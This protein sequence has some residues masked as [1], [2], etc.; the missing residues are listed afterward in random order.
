MFSPLEY[1]FTFL[2]RGITLLFPKYWSISD[3][4]REVHSCIPVFD[5][6]LIFQLG[7]VKSKMLANQSAILNVC[8][9][10]YT[11]WLFVIFFSFFIWCWICPCRLCFKKTI[12]GKWFDFSY[13]S[14]LWK[15]KCFFFFF[16]QLFG[17]LFESIILVSYMQTLRTT[18]KIPAI[19]GR[20]FSSFTKENYLRLKEFWILLTC[21]T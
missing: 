18:I 14:S 17:D 21:F 4:R 1:F 13:C 12:C 3:I 19:L 20:N 2:F 10:D 9:I 7:K 5:R 6:F 16:I 15:I 8:F 11:L